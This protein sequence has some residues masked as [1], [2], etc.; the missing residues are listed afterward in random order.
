MSAK[1]AVRCLNTLTNLEHYNAT[2]GP[3]SSSYPFF[4]F[5]GKK[6]KIAK[7]FEKGRRNGLPFM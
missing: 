3:T 7:D 6:T 1:L 4:I 2:A 5:R